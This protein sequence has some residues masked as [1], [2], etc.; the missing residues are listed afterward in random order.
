MTAVYN[1]PHSTGTRMLIA[2][3]SGGS[4]TMAGFDGILLDLQIQQT[5]VNL[6]HRLMHQTV[7]EVEPRTLVVQ[8]LFTHLIPMVIQ[9]VNLMVEEDQQ[10]VMVQLEAVPR[11][12]MAVAV[13]METLVLLM[14][15]V[16][17]ADQIGKSPTINA[18]VT[19]HNDFQDVPNYVGAG[20]N[21]GWNFSTQPWPSFW[22]TFYPY[23]NNGSNAPGFNSPDPDY[24]G[25]RCGQAEDG[26]S[27]G[28]PG[29]V[30][31]IDVN[32][33]KTTFTHTGSEQSYTVP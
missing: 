13:V 14:D 31:I 2:G 12:G 24:S 26:P 19:H 7:L 33:N 29:S 30:V 22:Q 8:V 28:N 20:P 4:E 16:V 18:T 23:Y 5:I 21:T 11:V 32:G 9:A 3:G 27:N 17:V 1:G 6:L 10:L 25:P 15:L